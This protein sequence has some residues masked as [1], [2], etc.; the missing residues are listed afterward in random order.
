MLVA[1]LLSAAMFQ[2]PKCAAGCCGAACTPGAEAKKD[3]PA[4]AS[5]LVAVIDPKREMK[6]APEP[7]A[8]IDKLADAGDKPVGAMVAGKQYVVTMKHADGAAGV[9]VTGTGLA[10]V[11]GALRYTL[12]PTQAGSLK[13]KVTATSGGASKCISPAEISL[14]VVDT[15]CGDMA[16]TSQHGDG[17]ETSNVN[18]LPGLLGTPVPLTLKAQGQS[19]YVYSSSDN[20]TVNGPALARLHAAI[21][22]LPAGPSRSSSGLALEMAVPKDAT[23]AEFSGAGSPQFQ[24][25][26]EEPGRLNVA[27]KKPASCDAWLAVLQDIEKMAVPGIQEPHLAQLFYLESASDTAGVLVGAFAGKSGGAP[28]ADASKGSASTKAPAKPA[29]SPSGDKSTGSQNDSGAAN[30]AADPSPSASGTDSGV[31]GK[32]SSKT[33]AAS[34]SGKGDGS[35]DSTKVAAAP[36]DATAPAKG[37]SVKGLEKDLLIFGGDDDGQIREA[38]RVLAMLD[39]PRPEMIIN[40]WILQASTTDADEIGRFSETARRLVAENNE[41]LQRGI[42]AGWASLSKSIQDP[43]FFDESF[44]KYLVYRYIG[45]PTS[46]GAT[47]APSNPAKAVA[48]DSSRAPGSTPAKGSREEKD[49]NTEREARGICPREQYCLGYTALFS[50][51]RPR[52][53]DLLLAMIASKDQAKV[54]KAIDAAEGVLFDQMGQKVTA[55]AAECNSADCDDLRSRLALVTTSCGH[56]SCGETGQEEKHSDSKSGLPDR[57]CGIRDLQQLIDGTHGDFL[58]DGTPFLQLECFKE[59]IKDMFDHKDAQYLARAAI[60]DFLYQYK[61]SQQYPH[62]FS[63]YSLTLSADT[64]NTAL[65]P[66]ID[67]FNRDIR[68]FQDYLNNTVRMTVDR[69]Q[70]G[71]TTFTNTGMVSVRTVSIN[72]AEVRTTT[73]SSLDAGTFPEV[74]T[75]ASNILGGSSGG[76]GGANATDLLPPNEATAILGTLKSFQTTQAQIG[77]AIDVKVTPRSLSGASAAEMDVTLKVDDASKPSAFTGGSSKDLNLSRIATHDTTTHVRVD[78]LKLFEVSGIGAELTLS[79]PPIPLILPLVELPYIG[80]LVGIP[81]KPSEEF[82]SSV[83]IMSAIVVPTAADLAYGLTFV[84]DRMLV[85]PPGTCRFPWRDVTSSTLPPCIALR[86]ASQDELDG[87]IHAFHRVKKQCIST[88]DRYGYSTLRPAKGKNACENLN[89]NSLIPET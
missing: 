68:A 45:E 49:D 44:Y 85:A 53:T 64:L 39:L 80:S 65:S 6:V 50:P 36:G 76:K 37:F 31:G 26:L 51:L 1:I 10:P 8:S 19:L 82:H 13:L 52:L 29:A 58:K 48:V 71:K 86:V 38:K 77:R 30:D 43:D 59:V 14:E 54:L 66:F 3:A 75:L 56:W 69:Q 63:P 7:C 83:A 25:N 67:A 34:T 2:S 35:A 22:L 72:T 57:R 21:A 15:K 87:P 4:K 42:G 89:F 78:S 41:V 46:L 81:R 40:T 27:E 33:A 9:T 74:G 18:S 88:G 28:G 70:R 84:H 24:V 47:E 20:P 55:P 11:P 32:D 79:R 5:Y 61:L 62:E 23:A 73:Q 60:A 12:T 17:E 16:F